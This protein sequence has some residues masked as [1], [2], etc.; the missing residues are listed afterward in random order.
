MA[1]LPHPSGTNDGVYHV[2][3]LRYAR[4]MT[5][6]AAD[7]FLTR[8][9]DLHDRLMPSS[10]YV[11]IIANCHRTILVDTGFGARAAKER[12]RELDVDPVDA[13]SR[14]GIDPGTL[15]DV[16][17]TH[18]HFDHAG[19]IDRFAKAR[20]HVQ[21]SEV[22]FATG[23]CMCEPMLRMPFD[24]EDVLALMKR[25]YSDRVVFHDGEGAPF[26][27]ITVHNLPGHSMGVQAV[28]V[29]T[30]RGPVLLAS[31]VTH[32]YANF[33]RREPFRITVDVAATLRAYTQL[34]ALTGSVDRIIPG[35]NPKVHA[36]YPQ[37]EVG[38]LELSMLHE[39]PAPHS[40]AELASIGDL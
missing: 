1:T 34:M 31:D 14:L 3:A 13:L 37:I 24:I 10:Y 2:Y 23:P 28:R 33:L 16:I 17:V 26:P 21:V 22:A 6:Q 18:L 4:N 12:H 32:Y 8:S 25:L 20:F 39:P 19:N 7:N 40:P 36:I 35:H 15:E 9:A 11:W 30:P 38:G 29:M 27:G 5:R